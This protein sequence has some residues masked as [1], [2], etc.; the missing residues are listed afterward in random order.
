MSVQV[1]SV[2]VMSVLVMS[3]LVMSVLVMS[4]LVM[5][6]LVISVL[7]MSVLVMSVLVM[8]VLVISVLVVSVLVMPVLVMSVL[9]MS[10][11][12]M[13]VLVMSV[14]VMSVLMMSLL[15]CLSL[16]CLLHHSNGFPRLPSGVT[17]QPLNASTPSFSFTHILFQVAVWVNPGHWTFKVCLYIPTQFLLPSDCPSSLSLYWWWLAESVPH[18]ILP[19]INWHNDKLDWQSGGDGNGVGTC[20]HTFSILPVYSLLVC[21]V[22]WIWTIFNQMQ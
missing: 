2:L 19:V 7:V 18:P 3:V 9:V 11:L 6:V 15:V 17:C 22:H 1:I 16:S 5:P 10:V 13:P 4:V 21:Y 8:P 20:K 12:V 14:L